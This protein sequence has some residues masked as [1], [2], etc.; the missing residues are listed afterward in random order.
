MIDTGES[1]FFN[2]NAAVLTF[3]LFIGMLVLLMVGSSIGQTLRKTETDATNP[4]NTTIVAAL[5]GLFAF[6]LAFTFNMSG[7]RFESRRTS[8]LN[9]GNAVETAILR[10]DLYPKQE[11]DSFRL[12][13][14][15]YTLARIRYFEA[16]SNMQAMQKAFQDGSEYSMRLWRRAALKQTNTTNNLATNQMVAALN[17]MI[18]KANFTN[19]EENFRVPDLIVLLLFAISLVCA[20]FVGYFSVMKGWFNTTTTI[21][22][23]LLC[24]FVIYATLDLDRSRTGLIKHYTSPKAM[25]E[26]LRL[27]DRP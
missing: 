25:S 1:I 2:L 27:F 14:K 20:F 4:I 8:K 17:N 6:L 23:C 22:F 10:A 15:N 12:E 24:A 16:G 7:N 5:L 3:I 13:L 11:R 18:E 9:E 21:G 19:R 26:L